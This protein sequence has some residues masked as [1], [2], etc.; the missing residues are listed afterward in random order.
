MAKKKKQGFLGR[1]SSQRP[2]D[3]K[4]AGV[5]GVEDKVVEAA[6]AAKPSV[7]VDWNPEEL[8][9]QVAAFEAEKRDVEAR[10]AERQRETDVRLA[11]YKQ[12]VEAEFEKKRQAIL[13]ERQVLEAEIERFSVRDK[14]IAREENRQSVERERLREERGLA[15][16]EQAKLDA[17]LA[18]LEHKRVE[19]LAGFTLERQKSAEILNEQL[20]ALETKIGEREAH[21]I[22]RFRELEEEIQIEAERVRNAQKASLERELSQRRS[23]V[24]SEIERDLAA[25]RAVVAQVKGEQEAWFRGENDRIAAKEASF[26][27]MW[28]ERVHDADERDEAL[29]RG[30][31]K[32][33]QVQVMLD[34][35]ER[36]VDELVAVT[37]QQLKRE[38]GEE[39]A[40]LNERIEQVTRERS[41]LESRLERYKDMERRFGERAPEDILAGL[42]D[43]EVK[44]ER[45]RQEL[46]NRPT[47]EDREELITLRG[48]R[49]VWSSD[50]DRMATEL[51]ALKAKSSGWMESVG[52]LER[53]KRE[54]DLAQMRYKILDQ[55]CNQLQDDIARLEGLY[56]S[57]KEL[58]AR[59]AIIEKP[60]FEDLANQ[61]MA[62][63]E[64][65]ERVWLNGIQEKCL[66]SGM[67]FNPRL[68]M[69]FHTALKTAEWSPLT[70]LT[71][72]SGTG[73]TEMPRLY[74]RFGGLMFLPIA[75]QPNW[76]SPQ[77]LYGYFNSVDNLFNATPLL[78]AMVQA[79][80]SREKGGFSD[81]LMIV[82]LDEMNLAHVELYFSNLLSKLELRRGASENPFE[83]IDL[84]AGMDRYLV[85]LGKNTLWV[86]TMNEDETTKSLSDKVIDR[87]NLLSFPRPKVL[88]RRESPQLAEPSDMLSLATWQSWQNQASFVDGEIE[89]YKNTLQEINEKMG[90]VGRA[91]GHR[92]WQ[93]VENYMANHPE[94]R[95]ARYEAKGASSVDVERAMRMAFEDA[96]VQK[97]MPK[98]RG[99]E[100]SGKASR[101]C[102]EP[103]I[104]LLD[105]QGLN[106]AEDFDIACKSSLGAFVWRTARYLDGEEGRD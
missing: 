37:L 84:G 64:P 18:E 45:L 14:E 57:P 60:Y 94:V 76:D 59:V 6:S 77:S 51:A 103:I 22:K 83:E 49:E 95:A 41:V 89:K 75:V 87:G 24:D 93:S 80:R 7:V 12:G 5:G 27:A 43:S 30:Q 78:R 92:V 74:S 40:R 20:V 85:E 69:A 32:C 91:L 34:A 99:I 68:L 9:R 21:A 16:R 36:R 48:E 54:K 35:K 102:L 2:D 50:R 98:L 90:V 3:G 67:V 97:V 73:K 52:E 104:G 4:T 71:G 39:N 53:V 15:A 1:S 25:A 65:D 38:H 88:A 44:I 13:D 82:L 96:V 46:I 8:A 55:T 100:T 72:V 31:I 23:E 63:V 10:F 17:G 28:A 26:E 58:S 56:A 47:E 11:A 79:Q 66:E 19:A 106:L 81:R 42:R 70:V 105:A 29:H 62:P 101:E 86:G 33:L 61:R